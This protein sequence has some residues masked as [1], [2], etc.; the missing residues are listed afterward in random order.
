MAETTSKN[1]KLLLHLCCATCGAYVSYLLKK[2]FELV[3]F[4]SNSN[5]FPK[6]EYEK[7]LVDV[8]KIAKDFDLELIVEK[9][10]HYD[11]LSY[12]EG[13]EKEVEKGERCFSC[14]QYRM[15]KLVATAHKNEM[16]MFATTL[17]VSPYKVYKYVHEIGVKMVEKYGIEFFDQDFKKND[18]FLNANKM[19]KEM[20]FYRQKYCGCEFS[21]R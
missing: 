11:W 7:R 4:Y 15:E 18:G 19:S 20:G 9:Y 3:L 14:Y 12:I 13:L 5:I 8:E 16:D 10:D 21:K 6:E 1:K 17:S 2:D